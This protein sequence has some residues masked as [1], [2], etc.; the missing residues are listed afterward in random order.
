[1]SVASPTA[2][3]THRAAG[4]MSMG[5]HGE[6]GLFEQAPPSGLQ[7][8]LGLVKP[9][10]LNVGRRALLVV[11]IGWLPIVV[12]TIGQT[13]MFGGDGINSL[14][15]ETGV[16]VRYLIAAPLLIFAE[17]QCATYLTT[18]VRH[19][20][21]TGL[22]PDEK[23][24]A[25][26]EAVASTRRLLSANAAEITV[27]ALAYLMVLLAALS[28]AHDEMPT[29]HRSLGIAPGYSVAGWWHVLVSLPLLLVLIFGWLWRLAWW[30]RLLRL[31]SRLDLRLIASHPDHVAGLGFVGHSLRAFSIVALALSAI[32]AARSAHLVLMGDYLPT[33]NLFFNCGYLAV[34]LAMFVAPFL[35]FSPVL[36]ATWRRGSADYGALAIRVGNVFEHKWLGRSGR[37]DQ[38]ALDKPDFSATTDLYAVAANV[39]AMRMVPVDLKDLIAITGAM[40]LPFIPV[41]LLAFPIEV[42]WAH[43]KKLLF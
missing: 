12:L 24:G 28:H 6:N 21:D 40:L 33:P 26:R 36:F 2:S 17:A 43:T 11:L 9:D 4:A 38:A 35:A 13:A 42:I 18:T 22:V 31:I 29:W 34:L 5:D 41:V 3:Q 14:L 10:E 1:M 25:F 39:Y 20:V 37:V 19:F 30:A 15:R 7:R 8:R 27:F 23:R 32:A 16:H